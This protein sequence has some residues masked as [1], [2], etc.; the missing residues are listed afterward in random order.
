MPVLVVVMGNSA[1]PC[2]ALAA[3]AMPVPMVVDAVSH[4]STSMMAEP[5]TL[6]QTGWLLLP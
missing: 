1:D 5:G 3:L 4:S 6:C 2:L